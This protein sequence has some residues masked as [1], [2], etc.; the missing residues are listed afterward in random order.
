MSSDYLQLF[1]NVAERG[2][3]S[4]RLMDAHSMYKE[5]NV[6]GALL[7]YS[8]LAELGYEVAQSNV[9]FILDKGDL[10]Y[11]SP[12]LKGHS[13]E[14][15]PLEKGHRSLVASTA[16]SYQR[17][18]IWTELFSRMGVLIRGGLLSIIM[19]GQSCTENSNFLVYSA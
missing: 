9:A 8:R 2:D 18:L 17:I 3:W 13:L 16:P 4:E 15:T 1:K 7:L 6:D 11:S 14:R 19:P 12:S 10:L 5:G